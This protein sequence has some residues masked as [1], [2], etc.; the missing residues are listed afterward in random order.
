MK[1]LAITDLMGEGDVYTF[2]IGDG[3]NLLFFF[4]VFFF[5]AFLP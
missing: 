2:G 3:W 4:G 5:Y 1:L